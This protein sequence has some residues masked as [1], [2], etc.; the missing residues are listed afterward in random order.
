[1]I[2]NVSFALIIFYN[3]VLHLWCLFGVGLESFEKA[4]LKVASASSHFNPNYLK[5]PIQT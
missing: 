4:C 2:F 5:W 1:M 3:V